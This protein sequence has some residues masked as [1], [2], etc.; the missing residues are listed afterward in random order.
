MGAPNFALM[1]QEY[2]R[3]ANTNK[4]GFSFELSQIGVEFA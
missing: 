3:A 1:L 2:H 4:Y